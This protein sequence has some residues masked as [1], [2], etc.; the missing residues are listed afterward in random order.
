MYRLLFLFCSLTKIIGGLF[1][2]SE[3]RVLWA[4]NENIM[5]F[6]SALH[7]TFLKAWGFTFGINPADTHEHYRALNKLIFIEFNPH[8]SSAV[9]IEGEYGKWLCHE[10]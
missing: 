10:F 9:T 2:L 1:C 7:F 6:Q 3:F 8:K 4:S 5:H